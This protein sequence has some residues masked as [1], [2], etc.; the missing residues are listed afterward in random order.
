MITATIPTTTTGRGE[1]TGPEP[2]WIQLAGVAFWATF[3]ERGLTRLEFADTPTAGTPGST[4]AAAQLAQELQEYLSGQRR[5]FSVPVDLSA[6]PAFQQQGLAACREVPAGAVVPY[7]E[8]ARR[9]GR[10][11]AARAVGMALARN[12]VPVVVPCHRV[13]RGDGG[14]GGYLAGLAWKRRLLQLEGV[15]LP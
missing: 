3:S 14:L 2:A 5:S 1:A 6:C 7:A 13:V 11:H 10:P 8:L 15:S 9:I 12:P 4:P